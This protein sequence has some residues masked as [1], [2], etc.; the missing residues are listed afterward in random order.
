[1]NTDQANKL[2]LP[3]IIIKMGGVF[4]YKDAHGSLWYQSP[5]RH[6]ETEPSLHITEVHHFRLGKIW[7]WKDFG[8]EKGG[9]VIDLVKKK[10]SVDVS[11]ALDLLAA[12]GYGHTKVP[13][14]PAPLLDLMVPEALPVQL[15]A[16]PVEKTEIEQQQQSTLRA[17]PRVVSEPVFGD[18]VLEDLS[19]RALKG[20]LY[21]RGIGFWIAK[22][23]VKEMH[24]SYNDKPFFALAFP[25]DLGDYEL[26]NPYY[27]GVYGRKA[28]TTLHRD[29]MQEGG[30]V[31]VF[32]GFMDFLSYLV[33][34]EMKPRSTVI[35]LNSVELKQEAVKA[36]RELKA[37]TVEAYPDNDDA[38]RK[39]MAYLRE[40]LP[41]VH[42]EDKSSLYADLGYND[43]ND[44]L[45]AEK[46]KVTKQAMLR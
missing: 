23:Y 22:P 41:R 35:V 5:L 46:A 31:L 27:Q 14:K 43:F 17:K 29:K 16:E 37:G 2:P 6:A 4:K 32:E 42:I 20:Y 38:G 21:G 13:P 30:K 45:K 26:R 12:W 39:L 10:Y 1:M 33:W 9:K 18:V 8:D 44:L 40:N 28:I 11:G 24:Y 34:Y 19:N 36:I 7:V 25:N 3:D 15:Q